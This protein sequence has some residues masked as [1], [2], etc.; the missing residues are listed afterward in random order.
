V[1]IEEVV[2]GQKANSEIASAN[3]FNEEPSSG[4]EYVMVK[5]K[6]EYVDGNDPAS[7]GSWDFKAYS[8]DVELE[9]SY[10]V[11]PDNYKEFTMGDIMPGGTKTGWLTYSVPQNKEVIMS[12]QPNMFS[13][14]V[15]YISIG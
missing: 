6:L 8:D 14:N 4:Y 15:A 12:Y 7:T 5:A 13:S 2:R 9:T 11:K 3:M 10:V 1:S